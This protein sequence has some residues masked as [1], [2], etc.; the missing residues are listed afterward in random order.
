[1]NSKHLQ[2]AQESEEA[3]V[4]SLEAQGYK[5]V[6]RNKEVDVT[7][8]CKGEEF[9]FEV[10][11]SILDRDGKFFGAA[12][13]TQMEFAL[14][15]RA[16]FKFVIAQRIKGVWSFDLYTV[17][18]FL[19]FCLNFSFRFPFNIPKGKVS[20]NKSGLTISRLKELIKFH[21]DSRL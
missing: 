9:Y 1:M 12:T 2:T 4:K 20:R 3:F 8:E 15:N 19:K 21:H 7:A 16:K 6:S 14:K 5:I 17:E 11:S 18:E 13:I 10:K